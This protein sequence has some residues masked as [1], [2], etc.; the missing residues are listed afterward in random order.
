[1]SDIPYLSVIIPAYNEAE[2]LPETLVLLKDFLERQE[3]PS[4]VIVVDDGSKDRTVELAKEIQN[5][6]PELRIIENA[7]NRGKGAVV[8]QGILAARGR[9]RLFMDADNST[10]ATE[11]PHLLKEVPKYEVVIGSRY[12]HKDSIKIKQSWKR[13]VLSRAGNFL[14]QLLALPG[15][16]DTQCGFKLFSSEAAGRIF[17]RQTMTGWSFD[18][19]LLAIAKQLGYVI[20]EV[21]V[22]W[23]DA[24]QST[25]RASRAYSSSLRDLLILRSR[26]RQ[27]FYH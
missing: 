17:S 1:M 22:D 4:E 21:P 7:Q 20:K 23:F 11:I 10:P 16:K 12:L 2:R 13:R 25:L 27:H 26:L 19:E 8:R 15:I 3:Y 18:F 9:Y 6:F 14:I 24:K 5:R